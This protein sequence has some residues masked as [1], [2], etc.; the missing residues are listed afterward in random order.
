MEPELNLFSELNLNDI[1]TEFEPFSGLNLNDIWTEIEIHLAFHF[2]VEIQIFGK[3]QIFCEIL[4]FFP[5]VLFN[6]I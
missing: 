6:N 4:D 1:W 2:I 3:F 5:I